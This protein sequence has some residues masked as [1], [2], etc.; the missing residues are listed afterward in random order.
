VGCKRV[1]HIAGKCEGEGGESVRQGKEKGSRGKKMIKRRGVSEMG[2]SRQQNK[3]KKNSVRVGSLLYGQ[4]KGA[5][6]IDLR[7]TA[8]I[9]GKKKALDKEL[10]KTR[11]DTPPA[12]GRSQKKSGSGGGIR[13]P[14]P[15]VSKMFGGSKSR[16]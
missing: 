14:V 10:C 1:D 13:T 16:V 5:K 6:E 3:T 15:E 11:E 7:K 2:I 8:A 12:Q 4:G 9:N